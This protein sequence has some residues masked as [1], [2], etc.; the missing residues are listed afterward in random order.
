MGRSDLEDFEDD[1]AEGNR[2]RD[3]GFEHI[4]IGGE[5]VDVR[6]HRFRTIRDNLSFFLND[7]RS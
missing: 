7:D 5:E 1:G 2:H 3:I 4:A 6:S